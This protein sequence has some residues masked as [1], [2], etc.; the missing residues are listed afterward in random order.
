MAILCTRDT[1]KTEC[2]A[3]LLNQNKYGYSKGNIFVGVRLP[4][5]YT[6]SH[7]SLKYTQMVLKYSS[8]L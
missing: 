3:N 7:N 5:E 8:T 1:Q 4:L 2:E 6:A